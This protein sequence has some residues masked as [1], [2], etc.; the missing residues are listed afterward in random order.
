MEKDN[1][2]KQSE[3][4]VDEVFAKWMSELTPIKETEKDEFYK[5]KNQREYIDTLVWLMYDAKIPK[6]DA[7]SIVVFNKAVD[8]LVTEKGKKGKKTPEHDYSTWIPMLKKQ[9][10]SSMGEWYV[11]GI[12]GLDKPSQR[13][14]DKDN[15]GDQQEMVVGKW[16]I[17]SDTFIEIWVKE[18]YGNNP[19]INELAHNPTSNEFHNFMS[20]TFDKY[21]TKEVNNG[22]T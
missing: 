8:F 9:F 13:P 5:P 2:K 20:D 11:E 12:S 21:F 10:E 1:Q 14:G 3:Y 4:S 19:F 7:W 15:S 18:K 22:S 6:D 17:P 16:T